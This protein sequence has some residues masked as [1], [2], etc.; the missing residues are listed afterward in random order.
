MAIG[1]TNHVKLR[2]VQR[3]VG[4]SDENEAKQYLAINEAMVMEKILKMFEFATFV[5][6]GQ[7]GASKMNPTSRFYLRDDVILITD[8]GMSKIITMYKVDFG[9]PERTTRIAIKDLM[10]D[11]GAAQE[12]YEAAKVEALITTDQV[13]FQLENYTSSISNL[14]GQLKILK[15]L[16]E[17]S[18][19]ELQ[20]LNHR[21]ALLAKQ[22]EDCA[23]KICYSLDLKRDIEQRVFQ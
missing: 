15:E 18:E 1:L 12:L 5:F 13:R 10:E 16:K 14:E 8:T 2:Y 4:I 21:P 6:Q 20:N 19:K 22:V 11:M 7:L 17:M 9:L 3:I 23:S